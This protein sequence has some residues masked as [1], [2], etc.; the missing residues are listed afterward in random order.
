M[1]FKV[2]TPHRVVWYFVRAGERFILCAVSGT[3]Y[4]T[5]F[6]DCERL[7]E[8]LN[9]M[10]WQQIYGCSSHVQLIVAVIRL[11]HVWNEDGLFVM[12]IHYEHFVVFKH[13]MQYY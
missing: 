6:N 3:E 2:K 1:N 12:V 8:R 4:I 10:I 7:Y 9:C 13:E 11:V 5:K